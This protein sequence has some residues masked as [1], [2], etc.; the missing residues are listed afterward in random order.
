MFI[1]ASTLIY[2]DW[3]NNCCFDVANVGMVIDVFSAHYSMTYDTRGMGHRE[4]IIMRPRYPLSVSKGTRS[5][6]RVRLSH[7]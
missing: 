3:Y 6:R 7:G 2:R 4:S 5:Q 1:L